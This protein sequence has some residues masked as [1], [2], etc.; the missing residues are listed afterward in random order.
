MT[1]SSEEPAAAPGPASFPASLSILTLGVADLAR[2]ERFYAGLG[3]RKASSS[4]PG[5]ISWFDLGSA[6][7]G[8]FPDGA[9]AADS[10][11]PV[12]SG[13]QAW[14]GATYAVNLPGRADV[15]QA[16]AVAVRAGARVTVEPVLTEYGVYHACFADPD[17]HVWEVA[18]N[19]GFPIVAGRTV[20]P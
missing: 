3:W 14:R 8:L 13:A 7:L 10:G 6:W 17:A 5:V 15:D 16:L 20:I 4:V 19:P 2:S 12:P 11:V 18:H 9:L 1:E